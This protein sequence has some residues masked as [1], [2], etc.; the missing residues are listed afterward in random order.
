MNELE[1]LQ[2]QRNAIQGD[3]DGLSIWV[4]CEAGWIAELQAEI[5]AID[6]QIDEISGE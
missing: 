5:E 3:L 6:I 1:K 2:D 4:E